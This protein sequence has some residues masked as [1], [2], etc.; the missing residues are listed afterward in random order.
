[1]TVPKTL[2]APRR[3][4][5]EAGGAT[6][7]DQIAAADII[8]AAGDFTG[9][10]VEDQFTLSSHGL[11]DG[12]V[13][14]CIGQTAMG[15]VL[16]GAGRRCVV[17]VE[18]ANIFQLTT[19]GSTVIAN[20]ADGTGI[21]LKGTGVPQRVADDVMH[22]ILVAG[23]DTTGGTVEDMVSSTNLGGLQDGDTLKLLYKSAAGAAAVAADATVYVKSP[24]ATV[25]ATGV[26]GYFQ[27]SLTSGGAVADTT[28]DGILVFLRTS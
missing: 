28:A 26:T 3:N 9:G 16:A 17:L 22:R 13:L 2:P 24:V 18:D 14:Y 6:H 5:T 10:T 23:N 25:A 27:T 19:D 11:S 4:M 7:Y 21:F 20:T 8:V 12:D 1:M 15:T